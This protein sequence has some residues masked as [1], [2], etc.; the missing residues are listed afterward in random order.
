LKHSSGFLPAAV[1]TMTAG[2]ALFTRSKAQI[3]VFSDGPTLAEW[4]APH[5]AKSVKLFQKHATN[6]CLFRQFTS[7]RLV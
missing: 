2:M 1:R 5:V 4:I 6:A 3:K 7:R